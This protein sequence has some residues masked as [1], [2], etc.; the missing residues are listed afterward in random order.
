MASELYKLVEGSRNF[1]EKDTV[2][3]LDVFNP[4]I[5]KYG[6]LLEGEDTKQDLRFYLIKTV[7]NMSINQLKEKNNKVI[8]TYLAK[9]IRFEYYRLSNLNRRKLNYEHPIDMELYSDIKA[10]GSEIELLEMMEV[11]TNQESFI[12]S[13]IYIHG[14]SASELA[15]YMKI[16]RQAVNQAKNRALVKIKKLYFNEY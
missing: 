16:S 10:F 5:N 1:K 14:L 3:L 11:L 15:Q 8:F 7:K 2:K 6:R 13:S 4:I 12:I 9:S